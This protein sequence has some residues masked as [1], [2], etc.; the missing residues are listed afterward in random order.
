MTKPQASF[1]HL[2]NMCYLLECYHVI[3]VIDLHHFYL[4][5]HPIGTFLSLLDILFLCLFGS[6]ILEG[7]GGERICWI[8]IVKYVT[9]A[10]TLYI[11]DASD[12]WH[13][14]TWLHSITFIFSNYYWCLRVSVGIV[15]VVCVMCICLCFIVC[16]YVLL[17]I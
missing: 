10:P 12:V 17:S 14:H 16:N 15:S 13:R 7:R 1:Y 3:P 2:R 11:V 6:G 4:S 5:T 9:K 8:Q